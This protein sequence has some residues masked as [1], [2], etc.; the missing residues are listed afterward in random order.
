MA[1]THPESEPI[2]IIGIG[3]RLPG[4]ASTTSRLWELLKSPRMVASEPPTARFD[5]NSFYHD[6]SGYPGTT[7][8]REAYYLCEDPRMFDASFFNIS[9]AEAASM[10]PQQRQLLETVYEALESAG[11][12]LEALQGSST[13]IFCGVMND[14]WGGLLAADCKAVPR[15]LATGVARSIIA[16]R[17]S[18][19]FDWRGPSVVIDTAC[20]SSMVALHQ[21]CTTL[22]QRESS[23]CIAAGANLMPGPNIFISTTKIQMLSPTGRSRMWDAQADGYARGEAITAVALKRLSDAIADG[24]HIECVIRATGTNQDGRTMGLTMPS[25]VSQLQLIQSTYARAGLDPRDPEQRC[26]YFEAHGTGTLAGDP[27]EASAIHEAFFGPPTINETNSFAANGSRNNGIARQRDVLLV[28]SIK[29]VIGH[30][31]G[32]AGLAGVIK[33]A[34]CMRHG[35]IA[36]NMLFETLNPALEPFSSHLNVATEITPWPPLLPGVPR[37]VSVNSFGFGGTNAHAILESYTDAASSHGPTAVLPVVLPFLYSAASKQ[38]LCAV[39][40]S[41]VQYLKQNP[42]PD[43]MSYA[44]ALYFRRS[45]LACRLAFSASG[46][47]DLIIKLQAEADAVKTKTSTRANSQKSS[48]PSPRILG[49]FTGQGA[50]WAQM[51]LDLVSTSRKACSWLREMDEALSQLPP[52]YRPSFSL[53]DEISNPDCNLA[54]ASV[55]QPLCTALQIVLVNFLNALGVSFTVVVGHSSGE[56]AAAYAVGLMAASDAIKVAYLRGY[57][58]SRAGTDNGQRGA[59]LA[60][61]LSAEEAAETCADYQGRVT[62]A[63]SNSSSNVT[64]SGDAD[65]IHELDRKF[66]DCDKFSRLL[67]VDTAYHSHHM[68]RCS[69]PYLEALRECGISPLLGSDTAWYSSVYPGTNM[70][71]MKHRLSLRDEYWNENMLKPVLFSQALTAA[72]G[73][74]KGLPDAII[75]VGP[76]PAL[77]G[78]VQQTI[79]ESFPTAPAVAYVAPCERGCSGLGS[80]ASTIGSIWEA[81]GYG[82]LDMTSYMQ[83]F[84]GSPGE[85]LP[86][87]LNNLPIYPFDHSRS[88]GADSRLLNRHLR[89]RGIQH[90]LLGSLEPES[91][92]GEYHWRHYLRRDDLEWVDGHRVDSK[93]VF[94]ATGYLSMAIE[95]AFVIARHPPQLIQ[96]DDVTIHK[97][98]V[99]PDDDSA[100]V[101]VVVSIHTT[102]TNHTT[103]TAQFQIHAAVADTLH[104]HASGCVAVTGGDLNRDLLPPSVVGPLA[105]MKPINIDDFYTALSKIGYEYSGVFRGITGL[106]RG[107]D[108]SRGQLQNTSD[109]RYSSGLHPALLD[110]SLQTL[111]AALGGPGDGEVWTLLVPTRIRSITINTGFSGAVA[112]DKYIATAAVVHP[113]A[114][115]MTGDVSLSTDDGCVV[116]QMERVEIT[117]LVQAKVDRVAFGEIARGPLL[118]TPGTY[119]DPHNFSTEAVTFERIT[120]SFIKQVKAELTQADEEGFNWH[121]ARLSSWMDRILDLASAGDHPILHKKWLNDTL[122]DIKALLSTVSNL[123]VY[124]IMSTVRATLPR[125]F[126]GEASILEELRKIDGFTRFYSE[127][128]ETAEMNARL[129]DVVSQLSFRY[130]RLRILEIGAGTGSATRRILDSIGDAFHSYTFTDISVAYFEEARSVF[131]RHEDRFVYAPLD[132]EKDPIEQNFGLHAYD[133]IV[134]ANC[135]HATHSMRETMTNVRRLLKP[136]GHLVMLELTN[137]HTIRAAFIMGGLEGWWAGEQD[138]RVWGPM[139]DIPGWDTLLRETGFGGIDL[140]IGLE[141]TRLSMCEVIVAQAVDDRMRLL[142]G[143]FS[144][145]PTEAEFQRPHDLLILGGSTPRTTGL[146]DRLCEILK[147]RFQHILTEQSD[148]MS[149]RSSLNLTVISLVDLDQP[150]FQD[151]TEGGLDRLRRL[152]R[153]SHKLLWVTAGSEADCPY[154]GLSKGWLRSLI[155]ERKDCMYQYMNIEKFPEVNETL[156]ATAVL[157]LAYADQPNDYTCPNRLWTTEHEVY[158]KDGATEIIRLRDQADMNR[159]YVSARRWVSREVRLGDPT[160]AVCIV[161]LGPDRLKVRVA[162]EQFRGTRGTSEYI[163]IRT[164]Y[165]TTRAVPVG[166]GFLHLILGEQVGTGIP[167]VACSSKNE[168]IVEISAAW[169]CEAP[170]DMSAVQESRYLGALSDLLVAGFLVSFCRPHH[171]LLVH[172]A[173]A[174]FRSA[175]WSQVQAKNIVPIF[176]SSRP[177]PS[178]KNLTFIH[179]RGLSQ[180]TKEMLSQHVSVAAFLEPSQVSSTLF[181]R[182]TAHLPPIATIKSPESLYRPSPYLPSTA[183]E[184]LNALLHRHSPFA[185]RLAKDPSVNALAP[186]VSIADLANNPVHPAQITDWT[187]SATVQ[188]EIIPVGSL[189]TLS[190]TK[191]YLLAGMAGDFGRSLCRWMVSR[192][193]RYVVLA[194]RNPDISGEWISAMAARGA[195]I[196]PMRMD[197]S[198]R[199]SVT[200]VYHK[201]QQQQLPPVGGI[202]NGALFL[203]DHLFQDL[204]LDVLEATYAAKVQGS[205]L[206]DEFAGPDVDLDFFILFGSM[207]G[208]FGNI[209]QTAYSSATGFQSALIRGRRERGLVGSIVH[210]GLITGVGYMARRS[211]RF[212]EQ[213]RKTTG[214]LLLSEH[215]LHKLF[216]EAILAGQP[217]SR[218]D[219]EITLGISLVDPADNPDI[220]WNS[221]PL[222]WNYIDYCQKAVQGSGPSTSGSVRV[223]LQSATSLDDVLQVLSTALIAKVRSKLSLADDFLMTSTTKPSDL[224]IDSLVAVDLRTWFAREL[225]VDIP[226]LQILGGATIEE[227]TAVAVSKLPASIIPGVCVVEAVEQGK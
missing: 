96:V 150:Y 127:D 173:D 54:S 217:Q 103:T 155:W 176:S 172:E 120:L 167:T 51:G 221:N 157:R 28:G 139:L 137:T 171:Q 226:L 190:G 88:Y 195:R 223:M 16:N 133:L 162:E 141:D 85:T 192:G 90:P 126:R 213:V 189:V 134:A 19:F 82:K 144:I 37:R 22:Q 40:K 205:L 52:Q 118:P 74:I 209:Q 36:P 6:D 86:T 55:S 131:T 10:D 2:A 199:E 123:A 70:S 154:L 136:G 194:S 184:P 119:Q 49:V 12:R 146:V 153:I 7:N 26:Q 72:L 161:P 216:A 14:D 220:L 69:C 203:E 64:L 29:T 106:S 121:R 114:D 202:A 27:Q 71:T 80:L 138:G 148:V 30:T 77:R 87:P 73:S 76:H 91:T 56:I 186:V 99:F 200:Q 183:T 164:R 97:A 132:I 60:A 68:T 18:Y 124:D 44:S 219:P 79:A 25:S 125:F 111:I 3:C 215:D 177:G 207:T 43:L 110:C 4:G 105:E 227:L 145:S 160:A 222:T 95:A 152:V 89:H 100:G 142:R 15:Y 13:G 156:L 112:Q 92:D 84:S 83:L 45:A 57:V 193:A 149:I 140:C 214:S 122:D 179:P 198:D 41:H 61:G 24:D 170:R 33:A 128:T 181:E 169:A 48:S 113:D 180:D 58:A 8:A 178:M 166:D 158:H 163:R 98:L 53:L 102:D 35:F 38:S 78:P 182:F 107:Q 109:K 17:I 20:S 188:A 93:V 94:P 165:S 75:E 191:T 9:A 224:G 63:A 116:L 31:E 197:L 147:P 23:L 175:V 151:I 104:V 143:P 65:A 101:E 42:P 11:L 208:V 47:E 212:T 218:A 185:L 117:P 81:T 130:P 66:K 59:M 211:S 129:G 159:R 206:L 108:V 1:L 204:T 50:Q 135:L 32:S 168:D 62:M 39:L 21:A 187:Q 67:R 174:I 115:T 5:V 210:P 196:L 46:V 34:L 225:E 201:I